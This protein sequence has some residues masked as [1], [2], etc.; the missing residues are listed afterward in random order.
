M[1]DLV[2]WTDESKIS[3][4]AM[5]KLLSFVDCCCFLQVCELVDIHSRY[6][7]HVRSI[8]V[9]RAGKLQFMYW[10]RPIRNGKMYVSKGMY[11]GHQMIFQFLILNVNICKMFPHSR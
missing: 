3:K 2:Q 6:F 7:L 4:S 9:K 1:I 5:F 11:L 10:T 8:P